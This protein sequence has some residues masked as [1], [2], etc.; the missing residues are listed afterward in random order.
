VIFFYSQSG[1]R[2]TLSLA[3]TTVSRHWRKLHNEK[4]HD[5]F[6]HNIIRM[7]KSRLNWVG[8]GMLGR[9]QNVYS[10]AVGRY[11]GKGAILQTLA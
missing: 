4:H 5:W 6:S 3:L 8:Y 2:G 1:D 10:V 11:E 9:I 7:M